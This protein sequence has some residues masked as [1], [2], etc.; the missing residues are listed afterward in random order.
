MKTAS[1]VLFFFLSLGTMT[2]KKN[3]VA[4]STNPLQLTVEDVTCIETYLKLSL[5]PSEAQRTLT[6]KRGDSIIAVLNMTASDSLFVDEGLLPNK[7]Y[8]YTLA[9]GNWSV[10][11][12]ATTMDTTSHN[13]TF[14]T[15]LLGDG[16]SSMLSDV[17]IVNDTLAYA[18]GGVYL[19]DSTGQFDPQPYS[20]AKWNGKT[21]ESIKLFNDAGYILT[22]V[23]GIYF[24]T[25][26]DIW[27]AAGSIYHWD[28]TS[29]QTR[30]QF[31]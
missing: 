23:R 20:I 25:L 27:L 15:V 2:C 21:W 19:K 13:W 10:S 7:M 1:L 4:P 6:L 24:N 18:V 30:N 8:T 17:A 12:Q 28:G 16:N 14:Q 31:F 29:P 3:P 26:N 9:S 22:Q 11:V 5:A